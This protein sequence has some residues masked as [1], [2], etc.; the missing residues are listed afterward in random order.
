MLK[1]FLGQLPYPIPVSLMIIISNKDRDSGRP[2]STSVL[3]LAKYPLPLNRSKFQKLE[4]K[5]RGIY[6]QRQF[7]DSSLIEKKCSFVSFEAKNLEK[8]NCALVAQISKLQ[9]SVKHNT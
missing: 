4:T 8:L 3:D 1:L 9:F 7:H 2:Q 6:V 5:Q